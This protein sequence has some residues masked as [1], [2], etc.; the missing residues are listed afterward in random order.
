[1]SP[2]EVDAIPDHETHEISDM[3]VVGQSMFSAPLFTVQI[4]L[5]EVEK[6]RPRWRFD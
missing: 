6:E 1:M 4:L 3:G 2:E 5:V